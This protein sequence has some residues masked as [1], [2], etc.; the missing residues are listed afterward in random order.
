MATQPT[1]FGKL[2]KVEDR[3][4]F[5]VPLTPSKW[6]GE[7]V[8]TDVVRLTVTAG[9][10]MGGSLWEYFLKDHSSAGIGR[11]ISDGEA[12]VGETIDDKYICI[13]P[14]YVVKAEEFTIASAMFMC[15]NKNFFRVP[16]E[17]IRR[18][19]LPYGTKVVILVG[20]YDR[21]L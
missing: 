4:V 18:W 5:G 13:N 19:L 21:N 14:Q 20:E 2:D 11:A 6:L 7:P 8:L 9:G 3:M 12:I 16:T 10:G 1:V 15:E 17:C